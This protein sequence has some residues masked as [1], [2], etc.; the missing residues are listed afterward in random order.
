M[1]APAAHLDLAATE[2]D[3]RVGLAQEVEA[4]ER[5]GIRPQERDVA[6]AYAYVIDMALRNVLEGHAI[7]IAPPRQRGASNAVRD[8]REGERQSQFLS[9]RLVNGRKALGARVHDD[10]CRHGLALVR[11]SQ[12]R[13]D[14]AAAEIR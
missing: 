5:H 10:G 13:E 3:L 1:A 4:Q 7:E 11:E 8:A 12:G 9:K 6:D 2:L 14:Q